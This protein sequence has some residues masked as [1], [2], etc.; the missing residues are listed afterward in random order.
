MTGGRLVSLA[1]GTVLDLDPAATVDAAAE[2]GFRAA[3]IWFE[4][5][6]W[7]ATTT[8]AVAARLGATGLVALDIEPV[9]LGRDLDRGDAIVDVAGELGI[10]HVLVASGPA[11]AAPSSSASASCARELRRRA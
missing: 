6:S 10:R 1:A 7:T 9:I 4:S 8:A 3:G 2:A 11:G 5:G